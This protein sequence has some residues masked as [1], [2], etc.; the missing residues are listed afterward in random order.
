MFKINGNIVRWELIDG[1]LLAKSLVLSENAQKYAMAREIELRRTPKA[2][3][4]CIVPS[5]SIC[6]AYLIG[7]GINQKYGYYAKPRGFRI[8]IYSLIGLFFYGNYALIKDSTQ[9]YFEAKIDKA[10]MQKSP[11]FREG[12]KE[13]YSSILNRN[14]ALRNILGKE[15]E[16]KYTILGNEN[17]LIRQKHLPLFQRKDLFDQKV[18]QTA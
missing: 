4:D 1:Q 10:L 18:E 17:Y 13:F 7:S 11:V 8:V 6:L 16:S 12:G 5:V 2:F 3:I 14:I 9:H 15:G